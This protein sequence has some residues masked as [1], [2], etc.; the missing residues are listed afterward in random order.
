MSFLRASALGSLA[1]AAVVLALACGNDEDYVVRPR[2]DA[3]PIDA[4]ASD[5]DTACGVPV[6]ATYD[7]PAYATNAAVELAARTAF[8]AL[9]KPMKDVESTL[10]TDAG[11]PDAGPT[12]AQLAALYAAGSPSLRALT[13]DFFQG[14]VD[15]WL[16]DYEQA[17]TAGAWSPND[18][19]PAKGGV[20]GTFVMTA[21]GI[22]VR[23][24]VEKGLYNAAFYNHAAKLV[25]VG[26]VTEATVDRLVA[27]FG[28]SPAF[29]NDPNAA[30]NADVLAA[31]YAARRD[32]KDAASPGP[33]LRAKRALLVAKAAIAA[34]DKCN[35][36]RDAALKVFF[37]QWE[38]S[39]YASALF[40]LSDIKARLAKT[41]LDG[42]AVLHA[43]SQAIGFIAGFRTI[44][45]A[46]RKI[47]DDQ[48]DALLA[49]AYV[50][51]GAP[52]EAF[53]VLTAGDAA[54]KL[55]A[56]IGDIK[57]I[58][59]FTDAEMQGFEKNN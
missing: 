17:V 24:A 36:D 30:S 4:T 26:P 18:P 22:D 58:Y 59:A 32:A 16:Q 52:A 50:P 19:P 2:L 42:P 20:Y 12:Q 51:N 31:G 14:K 48:I 25:A 13:T 28:A 47:T 45:P 39:Q 23:Q 15:A 44:D 21:R 29:A 49:K 10:A 41:P 53:K 55:D 3:G 8:D 37:G 56:V 7:S 1:A 57:A 46:H 9:V 5:A 54:A 38:R 6:P 11:A 43:H 27:S 33:Y 40:Y 35:G 34:G